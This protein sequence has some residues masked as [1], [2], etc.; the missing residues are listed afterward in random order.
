MTKVKYDKEQSEV[1][2]SP[3]RVVSVSAL[4][5]SGKT[6]VL[7]GY[8]D[9]NKDSS[10]LYCALNKTIIESTK[11]KKRKNVFCKTFHSLAYS[12]VGKKYKHK[13]VSKI[14][15]SSILD[16][17]YLPIN[18]KTI[19]VARAI[20][21]SITVYTYS[22][23]V[24]IDVFLDNFTNKF[25]SYSRE[26][27]EYTKIIWEKMI[28]T[29]NRFPVTH[30]FYLKLLQLN[31]QEIYYERILFDEGQDGNPAMFSLLMNHIKSK[32][33]D[34]KV[35][36]VGDE[37]QSINSF[38]GAINFFERIT[39]SKG[40]NLNN[41]YRF[42]KNIANVVNDVLWALGT[43]R[44]VN[45]VSSNDGIIDKKDVD[46]FV[47]IARSNATLFNRAIKAIDAGGT[48]AFFGGIDN[49][50]FD[51]LRDI[52]YLKRNEKKKIINPYISNFSSFNEL[53]RF[54]GAF[55]D[56]EL[57]FFSHLVENRGDIPSL[58][59]KL[60]SSVSR[61]DEAEMLLTTAHKSKGYE[62]KN[63]VLANDFY[64]PLNS[65]GE[66]KT[67]INSEELRVLYVA[68]SRAKETLKR[69]KAL[70]DINSFRNNKKI[71]TK[72]GEEEFFIDKI[73][74][75]GSFYDF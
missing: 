71:I 10:M 20:L 47:L 41:S 73:N 28:D 39:P 48:V 37:N 45:G 14:E 17:L 63:V 2:N 38:R 6:T 60:Y 46:K 55:N 5:G 32:N 3:L 9:K 15:L 43:G 27:C 35:V 7:D 4:A 21:E 52:F 62:F 19:Y 13:L 54:A 40:Y 30:D 31:P 24:D 34:K 18:D 53:K 67:K 26:I 56:R 66:M 57:L 50:G 68:A 44:S 8:A 72:N 33:I 51:V 22:D 29:S 12:L 69:N 74:K 42:G 16:A 75:K 65:Y 25:D 11:L 61:I 64:T 23:K 59:K 70:L 1:I 36:I 49:Y 58:I